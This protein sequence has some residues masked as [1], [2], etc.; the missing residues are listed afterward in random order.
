LIYQMKETAMQNR[1]VLLQTS[2][3]WIQAYQEKTG[4]DFNDT[5]LALLD[6]I[7]LDV[8]S[9]KASQNQRDE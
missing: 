2:F 9:L 8:Q 4:A 1:T 5:L 7:R 3:K 6:N